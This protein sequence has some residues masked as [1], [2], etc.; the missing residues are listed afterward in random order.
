M[1]RILIFILMIISSISIL[2]LTCYAV[3]IEEDYY[4]D[5]LSSTVDSDTLKKLEE[6]GIKD[7]TSDEIFNVSFTSIGDYFSKDLLDKSF[8]ILSAF[9]K[10]FSLLILLITFKAFLCSDDNKSISI[11]GA[12][13]IAILSVDLCADLLETLLSTMKTGGNFML[14]FIPI[15][16]VILSLGGSVS[17][18]IT[19]NSVTFAFAQFISFLV[20][21]FAADATGAFLSISLAFS[22][23]STINF[24]RFISSINKLVSILIGLLSSGFAAILSV[25]GVLS[26]AIDSA[27]SKS[28][29]FL[30]G[31]LIPIVGSSISDAYS[32]VLGSIN[33]I[34]SSVAVAGIIIMLVITV[35]VILEGVIY[36]LGFTIM[37]Y[38]SDMAELYE[39]SSVIR[40]FYSAVRTVILLNILQLFILVVSTA[41]IVSAKGGV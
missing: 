3:E 33:V 4:S 17:T 40:A 28:I 25:R 12:I 24:N 8:E 22:L 6:I 16:T 18:G 21:N 20:N 10:I 7:F 2:S 39:I 29:K 41:I 1:K 23:N 36:C 37:S 35:P 14:S 34:R 11:I 13:T 19:Y 38:V 31:S 15:Y 5:L 27:T 32:T 9:F 26:V 30:I